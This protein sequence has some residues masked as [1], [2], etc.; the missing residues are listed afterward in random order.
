M[1]N[2]RRL[3]VGDSETRNWLQVPI[4][5]TVWL[6]YLK[7]IKTPTNLQGTGTGAVLYFSGWLSM[8]KWL[9]VHHT[10]PSSLGWSAVVD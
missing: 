6:R 1:E 10:K 4:P 8:A 7:L 3:Q 5:Q 9:R 2:K